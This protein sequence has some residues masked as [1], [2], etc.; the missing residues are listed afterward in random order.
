MKQIVKDIKKSFK[1]ERST[2]RYYIIKSKINNDEKVKKGKK[3]AAMKNQLIFCLI[4]LKKINGP[5]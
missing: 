1:L 3:K 5:I 2:K 4:T